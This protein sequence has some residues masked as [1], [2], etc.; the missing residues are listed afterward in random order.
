MTLKYA[1]KPDSN[2]HIKSNIDL[3]GKLLPIENIMKQELL[4]MSSY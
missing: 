2:T 3:Y 1:K 4:N